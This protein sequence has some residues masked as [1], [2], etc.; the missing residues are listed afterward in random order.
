MK[1]KDYD[2][3]LQSI[4]AMNTPSGIMYDKVSV[5]KYFYTIHYLVPVDDAIHYLDKL[6]DRLISED[7]I[8]FAL[9]I[10]EH[11]RKAALAEAERKAEIKERQIQNEV[12]SLENAFAVAVPE[13]GAVFIVPFD[14]NSFSDEF[15]E[16]IDKN[17][18][19]SVN[20]LKLVFDNVAFIDGK[21][22]IDSGLSLEEK[23]WLLAG[24]KARETHYVSV[25][26]VNESILKLAKDYVKSLKTSV[27]IK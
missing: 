9:D 22:V 3:N 21:S 18:Q 5:I 27:F 7:V 23:N 26:R 10:K 14:R 11:Q 4:P 19:L 17:G 6:Q 16:R 20:E 8:L 12:A 1:F 25:A 15:K 2:F 13:V 24:L